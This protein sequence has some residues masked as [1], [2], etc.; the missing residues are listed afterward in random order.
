MNTI[1][2][3]ED[4]KEIS[5]MIQDYLTG[6]SF[7][8][9]SAYDGEEAM[10]LFRSNHYD[11]ALID[12]MLPNC[13][14]MDIVKEIRKT[15]VIPIIIVTAKDSDIDKTM[16]LNLGADD[17]VT[18][19]FSL[20]ELSAR[21]KAN[22]RRSTKYS[23]GDAAE[24]NIIKI[25]DLVIDKY[26]HIVECKGARVE[27]T[28]IEFEILRILASNPGHAFSKEQ[29][30]EM[31]WNEPYYGNENVLNTHM[32]RVRGKLR[33]ISHEGTEYIK[34]LWGIGYKMEDK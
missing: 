13:S 14:G 25:R 21:I 2:L 16:G 32:N 27:M 20:I 28:H 3:L 29:L 24:K 26:R 9:D 6:E 15:S 22:I 4:D 23:I 7:K 10:T 11:L 17:Y 34:T 18:K 12:L 1:L 31:I 8:V 5:E 33:S 19:P 30:Y